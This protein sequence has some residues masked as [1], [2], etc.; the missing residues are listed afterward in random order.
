V[1]LT[2]A[3]RRVVVFLCL[4]VP[5]S[6]LFWMSQAQV[7]NVY[8]LWVRDHVDLSIAGWPVPV[9]WFQALDS[10]APLMM[11]PLLVALWRAQARRGREPGD[12][13][14]LA[15]GCLFMAGSMVW[16]ALAGPIFGARAPLLWAVTFHFVLNLGWLY[17]VP[18]MLA[19]YGRMAP[20]SINAM[21]MGVNTLAVFLASTI[22]GRIGG[23]YET[24]TP[25][26][27]WLLHA[28]IT[29]AGA[30]IFVALRPVVR[31]LRAAEA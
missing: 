14:K 31:R 23:L 6:A 18:V 21:M 29:L 30:V 9:P 4:L 8:N 20:P 11:A 3:E 1:R 26:S 16:L 12:L 27:F 10:L 24:M 7:W 13:G 19:F 2:P 22:G 15:I 25:T 17:F 28:G 5:V